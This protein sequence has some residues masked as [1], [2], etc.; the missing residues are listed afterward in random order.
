MKKGIGKGIMITVAAAMIIL[1]TVVSARGSHGGGA[2][3]GG[4]YGAQTQTH[5]MSQGNQSVGAASRSGKAY[6][7]GD[8]TG[9]AGIA[10]KDGTGY[11]APANR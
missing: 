4:G 6:G 1:P 2:G 5:S 8:A 9:N 11:G 7:P 10:P 3:N